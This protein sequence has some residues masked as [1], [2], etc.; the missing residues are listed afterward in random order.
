L[1][2]FKSQQSPS[3]HSASGANLHSAAIQQEF[4]QVVVLPQS[5]SSPSSNTPFPHLAPPNATLG[6][7]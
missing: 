7:L 4:G 2:T 5:Q 1:Q 6:T 3:A